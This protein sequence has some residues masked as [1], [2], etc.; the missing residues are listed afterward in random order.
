[1][2]ILL[3]W[4]FRIRPREDDLIRAAIPSAIVAGLALALWAMVGFDIVSLEA[5][6]VAARI[7]AAGMI[8][9]F[10]LFGLLILQC[11][12][13]PLPSEPLMMA[14]GYLYG[15]QPGFILAWAGVTCGALACFVLARTVGAPLVHRFVDPRRIATLEAYFANRSA[16]AAASVLLFVRLF[17]FSSFDV[18]SYGC[19]LLRFPFR[20]FFLTSAIG[21]MPKVFAF[22]Y[23]GASVGPQPAWLNVLIAVGTLGIL[24]AAPLFLRHLSRQTPPV[25]EL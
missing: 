5:E 22:T 13:A 12:I 15:P 25:P 1:M 18:V 16:L 8:G 24:I 19:G 6:E 14:A 4:A 17:A 7:R 20:W 21:V 9:H 11:V 10:S 2:F 23:L 3:D